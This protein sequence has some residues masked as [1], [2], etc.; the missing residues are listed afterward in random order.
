M[1][2][3]Y[4]QCQYLRSNLKGRCTAE[5]ADPNGEVILCAHHLALA[6]ELVQNR[7]KAARLRKAG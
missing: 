1:T 3:A 4:T 6:M 5:A 2:A 7:M